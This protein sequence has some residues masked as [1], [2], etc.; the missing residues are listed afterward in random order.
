MKRGY[1]CRERRD[2]RS[3]KSQKGDPE[4]QGKKVRMV[5][6]GCEE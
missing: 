4:G 1:P 3:Q 2:W 5:R 6:L